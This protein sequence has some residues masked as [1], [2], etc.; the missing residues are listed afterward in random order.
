M[1]LKI[2]NQLAEVPMSWSKIFVFFL[3]KISS[4]MSVIRWVVTTGWRYLHSMFYN[5][6]LK[7]PQFDYKASHVSKAKVANK[8]LN[9]TTESL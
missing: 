1:S 7:I 9:E 4:F 3:I 2:G 6:K 5:M 8:S